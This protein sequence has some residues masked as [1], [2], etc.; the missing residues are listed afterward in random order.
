MPT[1]KQL[2]A[3]RRNALQSTGPKTPEGRAAVRLNGV[4]HGLTAATLVLQ[5]ESE[6]DFNS[7]VA[8]FEAEHRPASPTEEQLV[9]QLAVST[10]RL[11]RLYH[12]E[13]GCLALG[14]LDHRDSLEEDYSELEFG[15]KLAY[16]AQRDAH[17][18]DLLARFSRYEIRLER[19]FFRALKELQRLQTQRRAAAQD[20]PDAPLESPSAK[21]AKQSQFDPAAA[22]PQTPPQP[23]QPAS[24][25][26]P[27]SNANVTT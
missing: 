23:P 5:G 13:A 24:P 12:M 14:L 21:M 2:D 1:Q 11:Q 25:S 7:L 27:I 26:S 16:V 22:G 8:S 15:D 4:K 18:A 3:N 9:R 6:S 10:W 17:S 20:P 19:S